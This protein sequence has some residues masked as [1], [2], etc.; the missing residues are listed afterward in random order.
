MNT[1]LHSSETLAV[2]IQLLR[3]AVTGDRPELCPPDETALRD[4]ERLA[5]K[6][7]LTAAAAVGLEKAG[8]LLPALYVYRLWKGIFRSRKKLAAEIRTLLHRDSF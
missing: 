5:G 6:H 3:A 2:L 1:T 8:I 4:L 7:S